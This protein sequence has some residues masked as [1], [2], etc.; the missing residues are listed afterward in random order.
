MRLDALRI[1]D[2]DRW[3]PR[4]ALGAA[5]GLALAFAIWFWWIWP[6]RYI[7]DDGGI[8][9]RYMDQFAAGHFYRY[10]AS[11]PPVFGVSGFV[12]ALF[13][14]ALAASGAFSP[15]ASL[16][17]SGFTGLFLTALAVLLVLRRFS[18]SAAA[19]LV[20]WCFVLGSSPYFLTNTFQGLETSLHTGIALFAVWAFLSGRSTLMWAMMALGVMS[21]LDAVPLVLVLAALRALQL[22]SAAAWRTELR[23]AALAGG[24]PLLAWVGFTLQVFGSPMPQSAF[25]KL[26]FHMHPPSRL[27]F[28]TQWWGRDELRFAAYWLVVAIGTL[29]AWRRGGGDRLRV[30][31]LPLGC[32]AVLGLYMVYNPGER[33]PWYYALPEVLLVL[34]AVAALLTAVRGRNWWLGAVAPALML[35]MALPSSLAST[36]RYSRGV[37]DYIWSV[38]PER[39]A[40][41]QYVREHAG[42]DDTLLTG[43]GHV[44]REARIYTWDLSGLNSPEVTDLRAAG[45]TIPEALEPVWMV[46]PAMAASTTQ[47]DVGYRLERVFYDRAARGYPAWRIWR[48]ASG[49]AARPVLVREVEGATPEGAEYQAIARATGEAAPAQGNTPLNFDV[50]G[51]AVLRREDPAPVLGL[52]FGV[53][54]ADEAMELTVVAADS[55]LLRE[56]VPPRDPDDLATGRSSA[57][58]IDLDGTSLRDGVAIEVGG[59]GGT[60]PSFRMLEPVWLVEPA[61]VA[62]P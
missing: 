23:R 18:R 35:A 5:V 13:A 19:V 16:F 21:K 44:A 46:V 2:L 11:D 29:V 12:H 26:V 15:R 25:A 9:L 31:A 22:R 60:P 41:G 17:V 56:H 1:D 24:L 58:R 4:V 57:L 48:R 8:V 45:R 51:R 36:G 52:W 37:I 53:L 33:M 27:G 34:G 50:T 55:V 14:G 39:M 43:H 59:Y 61:T 47:R 32:A 10:N 30:L 38:E 54:R 40:V 6:Q 20:G 3:P 49:P 42:P 62:S 28:V 7:Y